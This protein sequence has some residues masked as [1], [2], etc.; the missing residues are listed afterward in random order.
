MKVL[1][2][3][4]RLETGGA[5]KIFVSITRLLCDK[6]IT[7]GALLFKTGSPLDE[8]LDSRITVHDLNRKSKYSLNSLYKAHSIY[9]QYDIVH[10]HLRHI[11]AYIRLAQWFFGGKYKLIVHDHAGITKEI[12]QRLKGIFKPRYYIG[13][14]REQITWAR[15]VIGVDQ[16]NTYLL[17]NTILKPAQP[18]KQPCNKNKAILVANIRKV[19]N[20]E[21]AIAL[22]KKTGWQ[23]DIYGNTLEQDYSVRLQQDTGSTAT[24]QS[25]VTDFNNIYPEY[26]LAIHCSH[27][28]TGP[29]VLIEYLSAGLP[30]IAYKTGSAAETI[31]TELP[32]LFM[33]NFEQ[34]QW[35]AR[36]DEITA[37]HTL[38]E[39]MRAVYQRKFDPEVYINKCLEIYKNVHS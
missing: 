23:L 2:V 1:H 7:V 20:I 28:E 34:E 29:L 11:Y 5:E 19:K 27:E 32:E 9:K 14:N 36:I 25:G 12:P 30:F 17:E 21:F 16:K 10:A 37:D 3:I 35:Q 18:I 6:N 33:N 31:A 39:K 8:M 26:K 15:S 13:V 38:P 22:C 24:I 4:D